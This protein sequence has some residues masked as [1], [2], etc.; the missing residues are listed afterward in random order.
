MTD[1]YTP[2]SMEAAH[3]GP[4]S[5]DGRL[6]GL[7][8]E[9]SAAVATSANALRDIRERFREL[10]AESAVRWRTEQ[11]ALDAIEHGASPAAGRGDGDADLRA[12]A[13]RTRIG[14][15][16]HRLAT[17]RAT[18]ER[19]DVAERGLSRTWLFLERGDRS[20]VSES[21]GGPADESAMRVVEAQEA[22]R[23]R[24]AQEIHD[25]PAQGLANAIF[26]SEVIERVAATDPAALPNETRQLRELLRRELGSL[27]DLIAQLRP[28][29]VDGPGLERAIDEYADHVR[30]S[31]SLTVTTHYGAS[32]GSLDDRQRT[33]ALRIAQEALQNVRKHGQ[34]SSAVVTTTRADRD[35]VI[36]IRDDGRG[37]DLDAT[38]ARGRRSFGLLFMR[39][40]AELIGARLDVRSRPDGGTVVRL[41]IPMDDPAGA[42]ESG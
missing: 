6:D 36:E 24:M 12:S 8:A 28:T 2:D 37:F 35:W 10:Y 27:R 34:A 29:V 4:D 38:V 33:A 5:L 9:A 16:T 23:S 26:Q 20:L 15:M 1:P 32:A 18:L 14:S 3:P 40:R 17:H 13:L 41:A 30:S 39:E 21:P 25:G 42:K 31:S 22:E 19:L 7:L 11:D